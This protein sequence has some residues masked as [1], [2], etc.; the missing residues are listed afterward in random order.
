[1]R[2]CAAILLP[3]VA[4]SWLV[5]QQSVAPASAS[6]PSTASVGAKT[7]S[8]PAQP[9]LQS[10]QS[11]SQPAAAVAPQAGGTPVPS[12]SAASPQS[13][14]A[15]PALPGSTSVP[16][17][18][19]SSSQPPATKK[20]PATNTAPNTVILPTISRREAAEA[21]RQFQAGVKLKQ[22]GHLEAA[23]DKFC[24]AAELDPR[25]VNYLTAR[26]FTR[27][28]LA[29]RALEAGNKAMLQH[30]DIVALADF[31]H[32]LQY[33][34]PTTTRCSGCATPCPNPSR[35]RRRSA[36]L[37]SPFPSNCSP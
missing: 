19:A 25:N 30:N 6:A 32:A 28:E 14:S 1:M 27:E 11:G 5:A 31:Q 24:S 23:F 7:D 22:K 13:N 33:D 21:K 34:P 20:N 3:F 26:E 2:F 29:M 4:A 37:R 10:S 18:D 9:G 35:G 36:W 15:V 8:A 17:T 16:S 12:T